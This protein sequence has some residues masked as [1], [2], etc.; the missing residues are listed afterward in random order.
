MGGVSGLNMI[1]TRLSPGAISEEQL[2][3]LAFESGEAGDVPARLVKPQ[4]EAAGDGVGQARKDDR[5]RPR[6]PLEAVVAGVEAFRMMSGCKATN[7]CASAGIRLVSPLAESPSARCGQR[8]NP[9]PQAL[10]R[11]RAGRRRRDRSRRPP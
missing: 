6:L 4:D 11:E 5:D 9:S 8:S 1:P 7:S 2:K 3:P 10:A